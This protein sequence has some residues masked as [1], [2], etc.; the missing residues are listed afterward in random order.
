MPEVITCI[1]AAVV[2]SVLD[3]AE[4][5]VLRFMGNTNYNSK[6]RRSRKKM[7][8]D[9]GGI[10][11]DCPLAREAVESHWIDVP[12]W[13]RMSERHTNRIYFEDK[14]YDHRDNPRPP[15]SCAYTASDTDRPGGP[16]DPSSQCVED[17]GEGIDGST[18][19][20]TITQLGITT[21]QTSPCIELSNHG[22]NI[23]NQ[24]VEYVLSLQTHQHRTFS[25]AVYVCYNMARLFYF[26]RS[27]VLVSEPFRWDEPDSFLHQFIWKIAKLANAG[28]FE[29]LGH[30][31]TASLAS[32]EEKDSFLAL[33]DDP[34][35]PQHVRE[36][37]KDATTDGWPV[38]KLDVTPGDPTKDEWFSD[39]TFP[40]PEGFNSSSTDLSPQPSS[41]DPLQ[42]PSPRSVVRYFLVGKPRFAAKELV[43]RCTRGYFAYD[44]TDANKDNWR[45]CFLKDSWRPVIPGR[46]RPEHLVYQRLRF[47]GAT[48]GTATLVCGGDVGGHWAQRT[49]TLVQQHLPTSTNDNGD[50]LKPVLH[51]HYRLVV[52]EIGIPLEDF[53][54]FPELSAIFVDV[55]QGMEHP[56][57][58]VFFSYELTLSFSAL[59]GLDT[60]PC[61]AWRYQHQKHPNSSS[62]R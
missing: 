54:S 10:Y 49:R 53:E 61:T 48:R 17:D 55:L 3:A 28:R 44:V 15:S 47:F 11:K 37:F 35:L 33:K 56:L 14:Q 38:Y 21:P 26:D 60:R 13:V 12:F 31:P 32:S 5:D 39:M 46:T 29:E 9:T 20:A 4:C 24:F 19:E 27:G 59:Q 51:V 41:S 8:F 7:V 50:H 16:V 1:Q 52:E 23:L 18:P 43:G 6:G 57:M 22:E 40:P 34:S 36:G 30:D 42:T 45:V 62:H 25:Y 58:C 2:Q